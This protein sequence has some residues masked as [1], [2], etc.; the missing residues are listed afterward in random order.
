MPISRAVWALAELKAPHEVWG[1]DY[2]AAWEK[3][4]DLRVNTD[5]RVFFKRLRRQCLRAGVPVVPVV[6][7]DNWCYFSHLRMGWRLQSEQC[8]VVAGLLREAGR[9]NSLRHCN[10]KVFPLT[11]QV[12]LE[13]KPS[14][15]GV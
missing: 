12:R 7:E 10:V 3:G 13:V 2:K 15:S 11:L 14:G 6:G 9:T 1:A 4:R 5:M 8:G